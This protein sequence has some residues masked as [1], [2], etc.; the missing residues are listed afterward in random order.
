MTK[1]WPCC[2]IPCGCLMTSGMEKWRTGD[3]LYHVPRARAPA[4]IERYVQG[5]IAMVGGRWSVPKASEGRT[6][7]PRR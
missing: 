4:W 2:S 1:H 6:L 3:L 5:R 7:P